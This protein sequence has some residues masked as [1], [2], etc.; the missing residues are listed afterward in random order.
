M[1]PLGRACKN[2]FNREMVLVCLI[3]KWRCRPGQDKATPTLLTHKDMECFGLSP[4]YSNAFFTM[5]IQ[6]SHEVFMRHWV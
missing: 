4:P 6:C 5:S 2:E 1:I 3:C